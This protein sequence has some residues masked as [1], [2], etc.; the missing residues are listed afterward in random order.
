MN[1]YKAQIPRIIN[2]CIIFFPLID[3]LNGIFINFLHINTISPG[4]IIRPIVLIL[5][6]SVLIFHDIKKTLFFLCLLIGFCLSTLSQII[7]NYYHISDLTYQFKLIYNFVILLSIQVILSKNLLS[8]DQLFKS[9]LMSSFIIAA[10]I[11]LTAVTGT[12]L[13]S[14]ESSAGIKGF[15]ESHNAVSAILV[16]MLPLNLLAIIKE[17]NR[18]SKIKLLSFYLIISICL[19]LLGT[20]SGLIACFM[21][22]MLVLLII[23]FKSII[24][25]I[26]YVFLTLLITV[27]TFISL[28]NKISN[29]L[30]GIIDRQIYFFQ[31]RDFISY[32]LSERNTG[33]QVIVNNFGSNKFSIT[34]FLFGFGLSNGKTFILSNGGQTIEMDYLEIF[35]YYGFLVFL[36]FMFVFLVA[37]YKGIKMII[38]KKSLDNVLLVMSLFYGIIVAAL[39]GHVL[40]D[41]FSGLYLSI[42]AAVIIQYKNSQMLTRKEE[43]N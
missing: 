28:E 42:I 1:L 2:W 20:K 13:N 15:F 18:R 24:K 27:I 37:I 22:P 9:M 33:I 26:K 11:I 39:G 7:D 29:L 36:F 21:T 31:K 19:V 14:Y 17:E 23:F 41:A 8:V 32:L 38:N 35:H 34:D 16:M 30:K 5:F 12:S 3:I 4:L 6:I 25:S 40:T 43:H 10:S